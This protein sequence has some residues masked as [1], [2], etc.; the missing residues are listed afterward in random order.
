MDIKYIEKRS[1]ENWITRYYLEDDYE[2]NDNTPIQCEKQIRDFLITKNNEIILD[3]GCGIGRAS[4][5]LSSLCNQLISFDVSYAAIKRK[6]ATFT[7]PT[8]WNFVGDMTNIPLTINSVNAVFCWRVLHNL[9]EQ[10]RKGAIK[11]ITRILK[12]GG[13]VIFALAALTEENIK[14]YTAEGFKLHS[15][16]N[17]YIVNKKEYLRMK[18]FYLE[19]DIKEEFSPLFNIEIIDRVI[20][21]PGWKKIHNE[22]NYY[23]V[24]FLSKR[25]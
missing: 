18:H 9:S 14:K 11:S 17:T 6:A 15:E 20:E 19:N 4:V 10:Q 2:L 5:L 22:K 16:R 1:K 3:I 8:S 24:V 7:F 12:P 13:S 25:S 21:I 23:W